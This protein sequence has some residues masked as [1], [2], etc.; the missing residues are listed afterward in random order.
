MRPSLRA[1]LLAALAL[2]GC[3]DATAAGDPIV[4]TFTLR[5]VGGRALPVVTSRGPTLQGGTETISLLESRYDFAADG[6][7]RITSRTRFTS[8]VPARDT[9]A[10]YT[11]TDFGYRRNGNVVTIAPRTPCPPNALCLGPYK[12]LYVGGSRL[13]LSFGHP[14]PTVWEYEEVR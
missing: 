4:G 9:V 1:A 8:D 14:E 12:A 10:S 13:L 3:R 7:V 2:A 5:T 6:S 11:T